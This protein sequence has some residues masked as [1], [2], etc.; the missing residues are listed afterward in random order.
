SS[1]CVCI[2]LSFFSYLFSLSNAPPTTQIYTL[3]LH[4]ALPIY[5]SPRRSGMKDLVHLEPAPVSGLAAEMKVRMRDGVHLATDVYL[6]DGD[7]SPGDTI[8]IRL[9]YDKSG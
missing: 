4:D 6:P 1:H 9:P 8:L 5:H 7:D 2:S 3:S